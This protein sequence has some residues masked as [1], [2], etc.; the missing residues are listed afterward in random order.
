MIKLLR[1]LFQAL[2]IVPFL[3]SQAVALEPIDLSQS[4]QARIYEQ[5]L[6]GVWDG[7]WFSDNGF[8]NSFRL[9]IKSVN[10]VGTIIGSRMYVTDNY[11]ASDV[12][13]KGYILDGQLHL[14]DGKGQD[15]WKKLKL[16]RDED[17]GQLW[18]KGRYST[19]GGNTVYL[20]DIETKK[21]SP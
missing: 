13:T 10:E 15:R 18:L 6:I 5:K 19:V 17:T 7:S 11:G 21:V 4:P 12:R 3:A 9:T 20:G 1:R 2:M 14:D 16:Y 8:S